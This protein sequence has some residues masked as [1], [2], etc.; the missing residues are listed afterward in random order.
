MT[1][2]ALS[3]SRLVCTAISISVMAVIRVGEH[4]HAK[5]QARS[6]AIQLLVH[7][8]ACAQV[9]WRHGEAVCSVPEHLFKWACMVMGKVQIHNTSTGLTSTSLEADAQNLGL[10]VLS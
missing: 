9:T 8:L 4:L 1:Q 10:M 7:P 5:L 2:I 6:P 3:W